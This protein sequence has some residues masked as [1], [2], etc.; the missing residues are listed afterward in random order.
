MDGFLSVKL[1]LSP[2]RLRGCITTT[3]HQMSL[4]TLKMKPGC[5]K[6]SVFIH[7]ASH[8]RLLDGFKSIFNKWNW[9]A[10]EEKEAYRSLFG[11]EM[12]SHLC[13]MWMRHILGKL[14]KIEMESFLSFGDVN[15]YISMWL[16]VL[17]LWK[18]H[19]NVSNRR[20]KRGHCSWTYL[21]S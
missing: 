7:P 5:P 21:H 15:I 9:G 4:C 13:S 8:S 10:G 20:R 16:G 11:Y 3:T 12:H 18:H 2:S 1:R 6:V 17:C 14:W 19:K